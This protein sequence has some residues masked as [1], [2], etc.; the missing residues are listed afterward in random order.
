MI[1]MA[2]WTSTPTR[3]PNAWVALGAQTQGTFKDVAK[4]PR[5]TV[6]SDGLGYPIMADVFTLIARDVDK[7]ISFIEAHLVE[8]GP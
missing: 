8:E 3:W 6:Y 2:R 1:S 5:L 7:S 4:A